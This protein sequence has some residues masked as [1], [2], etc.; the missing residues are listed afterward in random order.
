MKSLVLV[1][2]DALCCALGERLIAQTLPGWTLAIAP[3]NTRGVSKLQAALP[4]YAQQALHVQP[5]LCIADTDGAC[6]VTLLQQWLPTNTTP[7][8]LLR[9][10]VSEAEVWAMADR[11]AF[12]SAFG[13]SVANVPRDPE[14]LRDAKREVL[15]LAVR[16]SKRYIREE[17]PSLQDPSKPGSGYN[18]H[19]CGFVRSSWRASV[20]GEQSDSLRRAI[21]ALSHLQSR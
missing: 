16:S 8:L 21:R 7:G 3:I 6:P 12:A 5:V 20:A 15:A 4:R 10:A 11:A 1:G 9:L 17:V 2:E 18:D 14:S 19:L 13:V